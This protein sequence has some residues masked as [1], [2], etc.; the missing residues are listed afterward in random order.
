VVYLE[1]VFLQILLRGVLVGGVY[2]L[3]SVGLTLIFG[4]L[5]IPH[6]AYGDIMMLAMYTCFWLQ[7]FTNMPLFPLLSI[8]FPLYLLVGF[9]I[10]RVVVS[11]LMEKPALSKILFMVG[12]SLFL[13]GLALFLWSADTR[14]VKSELEG[15]YVTIGEGKISLTYIV[16][17]IAAMVFFLGFYIWLQR[18][19]M[20]KAIRASAQNR[21]LALATGINIQKVF[22]IS[23]GIATAM[24]A[25]GATLFAPT[26]YVGPFVGIELTLK[27]FM[28][29]VLGGLGSVEGALIGGLIIGIVEAF[30]SYFLSSE[31]KELA[32][33]IIFMG[34]LLFRP[35]GLL[36]KE[37][38]E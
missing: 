26:Y 22:L 34:I 12:L 21:E 35:K 11:R 1:G 24:S 13:Q 28:I 32:A 27:S 8:I 16:N 14:F 23:F 5:D 9:I 7:F 10:Y 20:G 37:V 6:F 31:V 30:S 4:V 3:L 2:A 17:F 15:L 25:V 33:L 19:F 38:K 36:G 18:T 29:I